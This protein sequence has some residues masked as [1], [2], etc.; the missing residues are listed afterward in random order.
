MGLTSDCDINRIDVFL[1]IFNLFLISAGIKWFSIRPYSCN[2][3]SEND[4]KN[5]TN[6]YRAKDGNK[7]VRTSV[8]HDC[9][10]LEVDDAVVEE[11]I[12]DEIG[13]DIIKGF[14]TGPLDAVAVAELAVPPVTFRTS[15]LSGH[16][17]WKDIVSA[18][19][20]PANASDKKSIAS[21]VDHVRTALV[22]LL[23]PRVDV[24][25]IKI[26]DIQRNV[27]GLVESN[28]E[29]VAVEDVEKLGKLKLGKIRIHNVVV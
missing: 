1:N 13:D 21:L 20:A 14:E 8:A 12:V 23:E 15:R 2:I 6:N 19:A 16:I 4:E 18:V 7:P 29:D 24:E 26:L 3:P 9:V 10:F 27:A 22:I 11:E 5:K 25:V 28:V 17:E